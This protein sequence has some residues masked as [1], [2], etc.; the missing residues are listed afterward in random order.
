MLEETSAYYVLGFETT[1]TDGR[2]HAVR[3]RVNR[4]GMEVRVRSGYFAPTRSATRAAPVDDEVGAPVERAVSRG[5]QSAMWPLSA[6]AT[7]HP[8]LGAR[9]A[10]VAVVTRV[11]VPTAEA[12][13]S[14]TVELLALAFDRNWR[15]QAADRRTVEITRPAGTAPDAPAEI[16]SRLRL[17]PGRYELRLAVETGGRAGSVYLDLEVPDFT[18]DALSLSG[19]ALIVGDASAAGTSPSRTPTVRRTF[20]RTED[21]T[22]MTRVWQGGRGRPRPVSV[23][24]RVIDGADRQVWRRDLSLPAEAFAADRSAP[25][26]VSLPLADLTPGDYL[27]TVQITRANRVLERHV[28]FTIQ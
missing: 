18:G 13:A 19:P 20:N 2:F 15:Q 22:V 17:R 10:D 21:V 6:I 3:V 16:V 28:R 11:D 7:V 26:P 5:L 4:P 23:G 14:P 9:E 1:R 12:G 24:A 25:Y 8:V 27:L